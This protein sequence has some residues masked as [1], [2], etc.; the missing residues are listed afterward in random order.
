M[1]FENWSAVFGQSE[2]A[3]GLTENQTIISGIVFLILLQA[4]E[5]KRL[6]DATILDHDAK[7]VVLLALDIDA[8]QVVGDDDED[9]LGAIVLHSEVDELTAPSG[10]DGVDLASHRVGIT[11]QRIG[12]AEEGPDGQGRVIKA[13]R[14]LVEQEKAASQKSDE[15]SKDSYGSERIGTRGCATSH[16]EMSGKWC[17][18]RVCVEMVLAHPIPPTQRAFESSSTLP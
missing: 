14:L 13:S 11:P 4:G 9:V 17:G 8:A 16:G 18:R 15:E 2:D 6:W 10:P 12:T 3:V 5:F 1:S 7:A